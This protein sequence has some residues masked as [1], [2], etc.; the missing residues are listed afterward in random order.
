MLG[1]GCSSVLAADRTLLS[2]VMGEPAPDTGIGEQPEAS[3]NS[4][5]WTVCQSASELSRA[6]QRGGA[7][8]LGVGPL[9]ILQAKT[10]FLES[11][12]TTIFSLSVV[13]RARRVSG[14]LTLAQ[15][16]LR[17]DLAVPDGEAEVEAF[18]RLHGD[19]FVSTARV[20]GECLGIY[21]FYAQ[22]REK[23]KEVADAL[24]AGMTIGGIGVGSQLMSRIQEV[25][26][27][28]GMNVSFHSHVLGLKNHPPITSDTLIDFASSF[29]ALRLD[30]PKVLNLET[31]GYEQVPELAGSFG[32]VAAN[33]R[34]FTG[35]EI[36]DGLLRKRQRL[37]ELRHQNDWV[38]GTYDTYGIA[39]PAELNSNRRQIGA[40]L[41]S[42]KDVMSGYLLHP[43][44][45]VVLPDMP[46][47]VAGSPDLNVKIID[48]DTMG[49]NGGEAFTYADRATAIRTRTR[50]TA[51]GLRT[52]SRVDQIR[53]TYERDGDALSGAD[54]RHEEHGGTGGAEAGVL[55]LGPG[56]SIR[57]IEWETG[58]QVDKLFLSGAGQRIG[59]GGNAGIMRPDLAVPE[60]RVLLG[61]SGRIGGRGDHQEVV[62]LTPVFAVFGPLIWQP[63]VEGED[64]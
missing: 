26:R 64:P 28:S 6:I 25:A 18:V 48:G 22:S 50:L 63:V 38:G 7:L 41:E 60:D 62:A 39:R 34:L 21:T 49:G 33:R 55:Q 40:D 4:L 30:D 44:V 45:P 58:T 52:G 17:A 46:A 11:L 53:L 10:A 14:A 37:L 5:D 3:G 15:P 61:F 20:G 31:T 56:E 16:R 32:S 12:Q 36:Q 54:S 59:G 2:A 24:G 9:P 47:L 13:V 23:S 51:V 29:S 42:I 1:L 19:G 43:T 27:S 35:D 8:Q 57:R